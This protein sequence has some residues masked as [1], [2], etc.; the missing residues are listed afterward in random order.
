MLKFL[1]IVFLTLQSLSACALCGNNKVSWVN[2]D[3]KIYAQDASITK[4]HV[5]WKFDSG[6][7]KDLKIAYAEPMSPTDKENMYK[8]LETYQ[9][10]Y[11]MTSLFIDG[12]DVSFK[13]ENFN[14]YFEHNSAFISFDINVPIP[15]KETNL[16]EILFVDSTKAMVFLTNLDNVE[17][18]N[19]SSYTIEKR[20]GFKVIKEMMATIN[21]IKLSIH[22]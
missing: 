14:F 4:I 22:Q 9:K 17:I 6:T 20:N 13:A 16:I 2:S 18:I 21:Y 1:C 7:S 12:K 5:T 19:H 3:V 8:A 11:F 10:P 15:L